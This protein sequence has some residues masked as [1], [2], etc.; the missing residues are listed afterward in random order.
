MTTWVLWS[1]DAPRGRWVETRGGSHERI[2]ALAVERQAQADAVPVLGAKFVA[3][4]VGNEPN[5]SMAPGVLP[6][7]TP[8]ADLIRAGFKLGYQAATQP[9]LHSSQCWRLQTHHACA[10]ARIEQLTHANDALAAENLQLRR[11]V[12]GTAA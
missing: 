5:T 11:A 6:L 1:W 7:D 4:P 12:N 2:T 8:P 3:L 9:V 10:L